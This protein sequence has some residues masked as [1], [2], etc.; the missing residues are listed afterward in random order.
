MVFFVSNSGLLARSRQVLAGR[1]SG[2]AV[3]AAAGRGRGRRAAAAGPIRSGAGRSG[4]CFAPTSLRGSPRG[5][6]AQLAALASRAPLRHSAASQKYEARFAR[7]PR[8][9]AARRRRQR[10]IGSGRP[11]PR[12][13]HGH[14]PQRPRRRAPTGAP[15]TPAAR[16]TSVVSEPKTGVAL[17]IAE[18]AATAMAVLPVHTATM[19]AEAGGLRLFPRRPR[20][21]APG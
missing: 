14:A 17:A 3:G 19:P 18:P 13:A 8:G 11:P 9:C 10:P 20:H 16:A 4:R 2:P 7:R 6:A 12:A 15:P 5:R 1:P 21:G